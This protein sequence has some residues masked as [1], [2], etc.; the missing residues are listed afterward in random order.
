MAPK[1]R[2][3]AAAQPPVRAGRGRGAGAGGPAVMRK[4]ASRRGVAAHPT[5]WKPGD[6]FLG[7]QAHYYGRVG[8]IAGTV[9]LIEEEQG[10]KLLTLTLSGTD[11]DPLIQWA[12]RGRDPCRVHLCPRGCSRQLEGEGFLHVAKSRKVTEAEL[13]GLGWATN[14]RPVMPDGNGPDENE[15]LRRRMAKLGPEKETDQEED[16]SE[17]GKKK[18][19]KKKDKKSKKEKKKKKKKKEESSSTDVKGKSKKKKEEKEGAEAGAGVPKLS[20]KE[21]KQAKDKRKRIDDTSSSSSDIEVGRVSQKMMFQGTAYMALSSKTRRRIKRSAQRFLRKKEESAS[22][23]TGSEEDDEGDPLKGGEMP[24]FGDELKIRAVAAKYPGLLASEA[25]QAIGRMISHDLG[26]ASSS[27]RSWPPGGHGKRN[28]DTFQCGRQPAGGSGDPSTRH[29]P[30]EAERFGASGYRNEL[31]N[32]PETRSSS[33]RD[34]PSI[35]S[36]QEVALV[37]KEQNQERKAFNQPYQPYQP[38]QGQGQQGK[39]KQNNFKDDKGYGKGKNNKGKQ[40][41]P[42]KTED[43]KRS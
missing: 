29:K 21:Q 18:K 39:G 40:K 41:D 20:K 16:D 36:R 12:S 34:E 22:E 27:S 26:E 14:L 5:D 6:L 32:V 9:T 24:L 33:V 3:P 31:P 10:R 8:Q 42:K 11:I 1:M 17:S 19:S 37:Q 13:E 4:P 23:E 15:N 38:Y 35:S 7:E 28:V 2:R 25:L 43:Q 30:T